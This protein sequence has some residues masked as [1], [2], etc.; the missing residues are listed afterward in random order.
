MSKVSFDFDD[1]ICGDGLHVAHI[2]QIMHN[3]IKA[4][5]DVIVLT[6]RHPLHDT[7]EWRDVYQPHRISVHEHLIAL[8]VTLQVVYTSHTPKGPHAAR[9]GV[10]LHYDNDPLEIDSCRVCGVMAVPVGDGHILDRL[11]D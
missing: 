10:N 3:H 5:D 1:T 9:L 7:R 11:S 4:G 2:Q 8:G 6:A